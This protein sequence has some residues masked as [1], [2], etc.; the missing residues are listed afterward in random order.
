MFLPKC[1]LPEHFLETG[2]H[3]KIKSRE[4]VGK[5]SDPKGLTPKARVLEWG[6]ECQVE[7]PNELIQC[8][9]KKYFL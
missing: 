8:R 3:R 5:G 6:S 2:R 9:E 4:K 1:V 7:A